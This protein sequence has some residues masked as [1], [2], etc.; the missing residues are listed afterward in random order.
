MSVQK[1]DEEDQEFQGDAALS[2]G[3]YAVNTRGTEKQDNAEIRSVIFTALFEQQLREEVEMNVIIALKYV[4]D[5]ES[6]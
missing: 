2:T 1:E 5:P 6:G 3:A 4:G